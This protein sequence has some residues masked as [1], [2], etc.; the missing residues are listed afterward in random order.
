VNVRHDTRSTSVYAGYGWQA[1]FVMAG[2][3]HN[4]RTGHEELV[5]G[6]GAVL[7][8]RTSEHW[9]ALA[10]AGTDAG[11]VGQIYWL[12]TV[13]VRSLTTR[14]QVKWTAAD[15]ERTAQKLSISPLSLTLPLGRRLSGG[16]ATEITA[17]AGARTRIGAGLELRLRLPGA[18]VGVDVLRAVQGD[19]SRL[20]L[21]FASLL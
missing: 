15:G 19:A 11:S 9:V 2:L 8:T 16:V 4:P 21:F 6:V 14:A 17:A 7:R 5:G 10:A 12:P 3:A 20:R 13:R 1:A 18:A